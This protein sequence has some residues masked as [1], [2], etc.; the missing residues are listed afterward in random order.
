MPAIQV[1]QS[2]PVV[3]TDAEIK[4]LPTNTFV[5]IEAAPGA[6]KMLYFISGIVRVNT[7]A[8]TYS[9]ISAGASAYFR[10]GNET[11]S[12]RIMEP[13][14]GQVNN[15]LGV[16]WK[17]TVFFSPFIQLNTVDEQAAV[18]EA[19]D[20]YENQPIEFAL[21]NQEG[22]DFTGGNAANTM[23]LSALYTIIDV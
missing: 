14:M 16:D 23:E 6:G 13:T 15:W 21:T 11:I 19:Q 12:V 1:Y 18:P 4:A 7:I 8:G 5:N 10:V 17:S 9:N 22:G 3:L 2:T 20:S